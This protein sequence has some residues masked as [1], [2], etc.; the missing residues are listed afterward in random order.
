MLVAAREYM[1]DIQDQPRLFSRVMWRMHK[2]H[3]ISASLETYRRLEVSPSRIPSRSYGYGTSKSLQ[4]K[5]QRHAVP[6]AIHKVFGWS[7]QTKQSA[8]VS[9][10]TIKMVRLFPS[11]SGVCPTQP[12]VHVHAY[13]YEALAV[14]PAAQNKSRKS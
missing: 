7:I 3:Y 12:R 8:H 9:Q 2:K 1:G 14:A 6:T 4:T 10:Y 13:V 5:C 11:M